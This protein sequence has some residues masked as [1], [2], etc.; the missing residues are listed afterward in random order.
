MCQEDNVPFSRETAQRLWREHR[1]RAEKAEPGE[2]IDFSG[3]PFPEDPDGKYFHGVCFTTPVDF[4]DARFESNRVFEKAK[5]CCE[6]IFRNASFPL[7]CLFTECVFEDDVSFESAKFEQHAYLAARFESKADFTGVTFLA[8]VVFG[9]DFGSAI[10]QADAI[11]SDAIFEDAAEFYGVIFESEADFQNAQFKYWTQ[12]VRSEFGGI[13]GFENAVFAK[14]SEQ[15]D[16]RRNVARFEDVE[17]HNE[18]RFGFAVFHCSATYQSVAFR[19]DADF[20]RVRFHARAIFSGCVAESRLLFDRTYKNAF[21]NCEDAVAP[22]RLAKQ[23]ASAGGDSRWAGNYHFQEQCATNA[24]RRKDSTLK[25]WKGKFWHQNTNAIWNHGE[26]ILGRGFFG[27]G[28]K[29]LRPLLAG[30]VVVIICALLFWALEGVRPNAPCSLG[31][32]IYFSVVTF[33]TL[34]YGDLQPVPNMRWLS[35]IEAFLGAALMALFIVTLARKFT[36]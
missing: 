34:G 15:K 3:M 26:L 13:A 1:E 14:C 11:F 2:S 36:R 27:Y 31:S 18:A 4:S 30:L 23:A 29:P 24:K 35:G 28:E 17:F 7:G 6:A 22:Y 16:R 5:F 32:C 8:D 19:G 9:D 25:F 20:R 10:F 33:T 12:F 21:S